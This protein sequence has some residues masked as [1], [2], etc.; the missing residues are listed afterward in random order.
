MIRP[1]SRGQ[2]ADWSQTLVIAALL[3]LALLTLK[4]VNDQLSISRSASGPAVVYAQGRV[5]VGGIPTFDAPGGMVQPERLPNFTKVEV[6]CWSDAQ[7]ERWFR[8][9]V[10][11]AAEGATTVVQAAFTRNQPRVDQC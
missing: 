4:S 9:R 3:G 8:L 5:E 2:R 1:T 11:A 10:P 7:G 6:I